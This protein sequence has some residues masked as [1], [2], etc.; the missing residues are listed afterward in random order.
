MYQILKVLFLL[1]L[2]SGLMSKEINHKELIF[3]YNAKSGLVNELL[4]FAHKIISPETYNC[5][6]CAITYGTF[7]M[8]KNYEFCHFFL[9]I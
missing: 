3:I 8:D 2:S 7:A 1:S 9:H 5:N 6:L 4:D